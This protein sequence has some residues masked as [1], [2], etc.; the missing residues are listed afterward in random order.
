MEM[1]M[2]KLS[3]ELTLYQEGLFSS[4]NIFLNQETLHLQN[5]SRILTF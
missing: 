4:T 2:L 1:K 3:F 5:P